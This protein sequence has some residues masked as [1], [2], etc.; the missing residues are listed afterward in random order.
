LGANVNAKESDG[1]TPL[2]WASSRG[3]LEVVQVLLLANGADV[4]AK[5]KDGYN[6]LMKA[7]LR[8]HP[9]VMEALLARGADVNAQVNGG[10]TTGGTALT[11]SGSQYELVHILLEKGA[12]VNATDNH[13]AT[14]LILA[15]SAGEY[16]SVMELLSKGADAT[17]KS[18][19]GTALECATEK[20]HAQIISLL[21]NP[22]DK[23][24]EAPQPNIASTD[25][26]ASSTAIRTPVADATALPAGGTGNR[27]EDRKW[28]FSVSRPEDWII[29]ATEHVEGEWHKPVVFARE[30]GG[31]RVAVSIFSIGA[32]HQ[33]GTAADYMR[34]AQVDLSSSFPEFS[35]IS[36]EEKVVN[37]LTTAWMRYR[38]VDRG[39]RNEEYNVTFFLGR[40][41][42]VP[43]QIVC[44]TDAC[45]FARLEGEFAAIIQSLS[46]PNG[47]LWLPHLSLYGSSLI[48]C[49]TCGTSIRPV[50]AVPFIKLPENEML[51][52][53]GGCRKAA[54]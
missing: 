45:R 22:G 52:M 3:H 18:K 34:K 20:G 39:Q 11:M 13:G 21:T 24:P 36:R 31:A 37:N 33:G 10:Q 9:A 53:C 46:F 28:G 1:Y 35:L 2:M 40:D 32:M 7:S 15:A 16:N 50:A 43:F 12:D 48:T 49:S 6:A 27:Y 17:V 29:A 19:W 38:Y 4:N 5:D 54:Q 44:F 25:L 30:Q 8:E 51:A 41:R 14:A 42:G 23:Q 26:E 47:R